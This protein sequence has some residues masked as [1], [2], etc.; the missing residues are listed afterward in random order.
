MADIEGWR[1]DPRGALTD[2]CDHGGD[3]QVSNAWHRRFVRRAADGTWQVVTVYFYRAAD[4]N[5]VHDWG[6]VWLEEQREY[7]VCTDLTDPGGSEITSE[8][9]HI[10]HHPGDPRAAC[11]AFTFD[12]IDW[13]RTMEVR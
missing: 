10:P 1:E 7:L 12:Q 13:N 4:D 5:S 9:R 3:V 11:E 8:Y 6:P 2:G